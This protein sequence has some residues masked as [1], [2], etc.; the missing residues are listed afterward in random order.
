MNERRFRI[1]AGLISML[2]LASSTYFGVKVA[3]GALKP[4]YQL[5]ASFTSAGQGLQ[6]ESDVKIHGVD[7]GRVKKV[8]LRDGRALV[9]L[10]IDKDERI[11]VGS[12]ATIR[13]KTLFGEKFVDIDPGPNE[14]TGP[15]LGDEDMIDKTVGGFELE[16]VLSRLY[17]ILQAV[18]PEELTVILDTLAEGG[19]GE[20]P[21]INRQIGNFAILADIQ[22]RH[23]LDVKQFLDDLALL[24]D[25][26]ADRGDDLVAAARD[27]N[28]ALPPL[29]DRS[30]EL[31][32]LLDETARFTGDLAELLEANESFQVKAV[33]EGGK[34]IQTVYDR[35]GQIPPLVLGL[36]QFFEALTRVGHLDYG[37]GTRLA[38]IKFVTGEECPQGRHRCPAPPGGSSTGSGGAAAPDGPAGSA[39]AP[40]AVPGAPGLPLPLDLPLSTTGAQAVVDLLGGL[41]Q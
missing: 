17:P 2:F 31:G 7:V 24:S 40:P 41:L 21:A 30:D 20:G 1:A 15:F 12:T 35:R 19:R 32:A 25:E 28:I 22:A 4:R 39:S 5:E 13:P 9:R 36:R 16:K 26:L 14:S 10:D 3:V 11:P 18:Q 34:T 29:N 37:N 33:T 6:S 38:G 23:D 8:R 27:L